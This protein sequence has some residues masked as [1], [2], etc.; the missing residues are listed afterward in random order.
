MESWFFILLV[1]FSISIILK[2]FFNL[3]SPPKKLTHTLPPGPSTFPI[4]GNFLF[5]RK[6]FFEIEPIL[7]NLRKKYGSMVTLHIGPRPSIFV[8]DRS[9]AHQALVQSGS[10]FSDRP[11]ALPISKIMSSNQHNISSAPYGPNWRVLRRNLT[12]EILHP[13]RIKSYSHA[14]K[15]VLDILFDILQSKAKTGEPVQVLTHFQYAMFC[16]LVLMCFGDKLSQEQIKK[17]EDV[18][19]RG[20]L[21]L[22]R[23]NILNF[24]PKVTKVLLRKR[25]QEF[26]QRR[27]DQEDVLIPLIRARKKAKEEKLS[28]KKSDDYVLAYVDTLLDLELPEEKRKLTEGEIFSLASEFLNA[29]TDT[30]ST[31]LQWV[32]ANLVKYPHIQDKLFLE[33]KGVVGDGEEIKEDD[34]QK[35]P[36]LKAVILEGLRRH[37]PGHFVLPHCVTED[38]VLGDYLVPKNGTINFMVAEMGWDPKVWED[39]MAFK[40]ERFMRNEQMFDITGSR[41]IKMM[42]FGVGRRICPGFGLAL[43]HLEYFVANLIWKFE[44]KAMDGDEIS[45]EEKQEFTVVMKTPLMA[46]I[47][48]RKEI[49][50]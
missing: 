42:P 2:A 1:A 10:L 3:F 17:I 33:I 41:E 18:V 43:L 5:L 29:G 44:W 6:S 47:S 21:G 46:H 24:W 7:R 25:W 30:T 26:F 4:I 38:T 48:P 23:F 35:M 31:A 36:Y 11:K 20:L 49:R 39:P 16:L 50:S 32:M 45:L 28:D 40:P 8:S 14:R 13:S 22:E 12:S 15:W 34:L 37:P 19:R 9:L 27:K